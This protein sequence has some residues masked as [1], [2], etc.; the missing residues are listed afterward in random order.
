MGSGNHADDA[1]GN[2]EGGPVIDGRREPRRADRAPA[3]LDGPR[4]RR[5]LLASSWAVSCGQGRASSRTSSRI[6]VS[7]PPLREALRVLEQE[8]LVQA[9]PPRG[10]IVTPVSLHDVFEVFS[11]REELERIAVLRAVPVRDATRLDRVRAAAMAALDEAASA[12]DPAAVTRAGFA[13]HL[14]VIGLAGHGRLEVAYRSLSLQMQ[15][16]MGL[17]R[18]ARAGQ[19]TLDEDAERH[20]RILVAIELGEPAVVQDEL[21]HHGDLSFLD[22]VR[23]LPSSP[24]AEQWLAE[25]VARGRWSSTGPTTSDDPEETA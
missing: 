9:S 22:G 5:A 1:S 25:L 14:S 7:R 21:L 8:G 4:G 17:N 6:S 24:Q 3:E 15:L 19:E 12:R 18:R 2:T 16:C 13:F 23:H 20:S 11:L 10:T